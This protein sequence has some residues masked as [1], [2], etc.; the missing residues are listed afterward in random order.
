MTIANMHMDRRSFEP[1]KVSIKVL[2]AIGGSK[3][4]VSTARDAG[5]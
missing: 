5:E 4:T 3:V 2:S 1:L